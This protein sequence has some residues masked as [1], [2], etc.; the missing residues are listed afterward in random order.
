MLIVIGDLIDDVIVTGL[1]TIELGTDNPTEIAHAR[2]GS[3]ANVAAA[4]AALVSTRFIGRIGVDATGTALVSA[5]EE[6][7]VD[8]R[9]QRGG[10]TG[11]IVVLVD[12]T[13]ERTMLTDRG[14]AAEL[15]AIDSAWLDD[16]SWV[17]VPLYG[18][19]DEPSRTAILA[20]LDAR[21]QTPRSIDLSSVATMRYLGT[22]LLRTIMDRI[23]P[24]LVFANA[25]EAALAAE[26]GLSGSPHGCQVVKDG[27]APVRIVSEGA[28]IE[29]AVPP[30]AAVVDTTGAGDAF[31]AGFLAATMHDASPAEAAAAGIALAAR[32][33]AQPGAL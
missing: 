25:D 1:G 8:V 3:A 26:L 14:A 33:I 24:Q 6:R 23:A 4:A 29:I 31:A 18:L 10:R 30:V 28:T 17:H 5:L 22:E 21:P 9:V 12:D 11:S 2:G 16:A 15:S 20:A 7:G 19:S 32:A 27:A 13:G